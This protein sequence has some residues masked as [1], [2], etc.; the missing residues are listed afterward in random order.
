VTGYSL[1]AIAVVAT[2]CA[3]PVRLVH[4]QPCPARGVASEQISLELA[5]P[6]AETPFIPPIPAPAT[7]KGVRML[8]RVVVDTSGRVM[9]D[10]VTVCGINDPMYL[11]RIAEELSQMRFRPGLMRAKHVVAP[12]LVLYDF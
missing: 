6:H 9:R 1:A 10:S 5:I 4:P 8:A 2:G 11:Q 12:S 3:N 7:V